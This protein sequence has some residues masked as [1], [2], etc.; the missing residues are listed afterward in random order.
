MAQWGT[1]NKAPLTPATSKRGE[2]GEG[3][4]KDKDE[5]KIWTH[6]AERFECDS[7]EG[8]YELLHEWSCV[9][10]PYGHLMLNIIV[11]NESTCKHVN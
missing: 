1:N 3:E 6:K 4:D 10:R 2:E 7:N 11:S 9:R 5:D 8:P